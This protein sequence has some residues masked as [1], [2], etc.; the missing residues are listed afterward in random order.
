MSASNLANSRLVERVSPSQR[1]ACSCA[2]SILFFFELASRNSLSSFNSSGSSN[3]LPALR[4]PLASSTWSASSDLSAAAGGSGDCA[5]ATAKKASHTESLPA[6]G[7]IYGPWQRSFLGS[8]FG[9]A[10]LAQARLIY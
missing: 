5:W 4:N 7:T 3:H 10:M 1:R 9:G 6:G 8:C 2:W